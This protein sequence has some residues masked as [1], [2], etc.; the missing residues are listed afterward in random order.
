M[1]LFAGHNS[2][3]GPHPILVYQDHHEG[4]GRSKSNPGPDH[5]T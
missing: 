1:N 5:K 2:S 3:K 4:W